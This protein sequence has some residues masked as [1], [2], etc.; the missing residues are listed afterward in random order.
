MLFNS[1]IVIPLFA[2]CG[3][4]IP[5]LDTKN[6]LQVWLYELNPWVRIINSMFTELQYA[7]LPSLYG[8]S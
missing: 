1:A 2:T 6:W 3:V 7:Y 8:I 5:Y 4:I